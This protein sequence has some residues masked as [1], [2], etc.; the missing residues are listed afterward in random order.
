VRARQQATTADSL[1][2][3]QTPIWFFVLCEGNVLQFCKQNI[4]II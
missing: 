4:F 3:K 2:A 1:A